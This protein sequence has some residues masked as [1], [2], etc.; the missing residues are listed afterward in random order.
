MKGLIE[1]LLIGLLAVLVVGSL[2][3]ALFDRP[4]FMSYAYSES[5]TPNINRGDVFFLNP[6]SRNPGVG[7][8]IVFRANGKWTVHRVVLITGGGYLTKGDAN[9]ATDQ[10]GSG[11]PPV[12]KKDVAGKVVTLEGHVIRIPLVGNYLQGGLD[13][14]S[15]ILLGVILALVGIIAFSGDSGERKRRSRFLRIGFRT[16][17]LAVAVILIITV[18][19][20]VFVSWESVPLEYAVT[21]AGGL[22]DG[23]H[24]PGEEF[25]TELMVKNNNIYPMLYYVSA[26]A[27]VTAISSPSFQLSGG[28]ER[29]LVVNVRAP[30]KTAVYSTGVKITAYPHV[31]PAPVVS[32]LYSFNPML[33]LLAIL[34]EVGVMLWM[35]YLVTGMGKEDVVR[36]R[37]GRGSFIGRFLEVLRI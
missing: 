10:V 27:P 13:N 3:G 22:R 2:L 1:Y 31:L 17:Y 37:R 24:L 20:A 25:S 4:V 28:E 32:W 8:V 7:D 6:L 19:M 12:Q 15:K 34:F 16:L 29:T 18:A 35:I 30:E 21:S 14:R 23:W 9:V 5:M 26:H 33:P 11:I 36:I